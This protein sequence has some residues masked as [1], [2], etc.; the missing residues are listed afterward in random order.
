[1]VTENVDSSYT[2]TQTTKDEASV[3]STALYGY[4]GTVREELPVHT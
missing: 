1:M 2:V 3:Y 4:T